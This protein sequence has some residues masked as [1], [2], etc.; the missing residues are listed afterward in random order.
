MYA[1]PAAAATT[2]VPPSSSFPFLLRPRSISVTVCLHV[3]KVTHTLCRS[4]LALL[5]N[6][7]AGC[8]LFIVCFKHK[9]GISQR[10]CTVW[11]QY[12]VIAYYL[13]LALLLWAYLQCLLFT[14]TYFI[15]PMLVVLSTLFEEIIYVVIIIFPW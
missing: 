5:C 10:L 1:S 9:I 13:S 15:S 12:N 6:Q 2:T 7:F 14:K 3:H 4:K 11:P 8:H